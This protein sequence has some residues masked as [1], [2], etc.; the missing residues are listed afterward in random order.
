MAGA[1]VTVQVDDRHLLEVLGQVDSVLQ[2]DDRELM[3]ADMG[4]YLLRSTRE[5]AALEVTPDGEPWTPLSPRYAKRKAKTH[6]GR[7]ML[8]LDLHML[9]DML[10]YQV[11]GAEL[12]VGTSAIWGAT[13]EFGRDAIPARPWLG[14]D[15]ADSS[16]IL[17]IVEKHIRAHLQG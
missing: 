15:E 3:L 17:S 10:S 6:P 16:K 13:Q 5:R 9:G 14:L 4:E 1:R 7:P 8:V 11:D 2:G 12:A